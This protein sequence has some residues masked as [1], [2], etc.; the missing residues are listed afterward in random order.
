[1]RDGFF[2]FHAR[3]VAWTVTN[4]IVFTVFILSGG[5]LVEQSLICT[6]RVL[7][8][9]DAILLNSLNVFYYRRV[10]PVQRSAF[11][12]MSIFLVHV[13]FDDAIK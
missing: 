9:E 4:S 3:L 12:I 2:F 1:M 10:L 11:K 8:Y 6:S 5:L 7:F 13:E